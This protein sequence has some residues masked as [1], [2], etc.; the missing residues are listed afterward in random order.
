MKA[1]LWD[2]LSSGALRLPIDRTFAFDEV[3][4]A[5]AHMKA[6]RHFGKIVVEIA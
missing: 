2:K 3:A 4:N 5:L 1:D 6:N